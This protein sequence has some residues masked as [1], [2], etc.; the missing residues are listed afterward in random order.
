MATIVLR[1][2]AGVTFF[3]DK[4]NNQVH[5]LP[6]ETAPCQIDKIIEFGNSVAF[7]PDTL[8]EAHNT[9]WISCPWCF[10]SS[11]DIAACGEDSEG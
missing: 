8:E 11:A 5:C 9:G 3:G 7:F 2:R 6:N 4:S 10:G 1:S